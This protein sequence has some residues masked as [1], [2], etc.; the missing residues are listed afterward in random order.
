MRLSACL[1][2]V[3]ITTTVSAFPS[4]FAAPVTEDSAPELFPRQI[5]N[6]TNGP[7]TR[8][9]WDGVRDINTDY[10]TDFPVTGRVREYWLTVENSTFAPDGYR[11]TVL[12]F[13]G[14]LPGPTLYADWGDTVRIHVTNN[15]EYNGTSVHWHGVRQLGTTEQDGVNGITQCPCIP[16]L[17]LD[18]IDANDFTGALAP[19]NSQTYEW[20][21]TQ[22]GPS[23]YHSHFSLQYADGA[24][25]ALVIN[26][27]ASANYDEDLGPILLGDW[28]HP[29]AFALWQNIP[30]DGPQPAD[31]GLINGM[32]VFDCS[33][34]TDTNCVGGGKRF[35]TE[36]KPGKKYLLRFI[37][38]A[39]DTFF[40]VSLDNH[41]MT[42][43]STDFVPIKPY[44]TEFISI[45]IGERY[46]VIIEANQATDNYWLRAISQAACGAA[47]TNRLNIRGIVQYSGAKNTE[48]TS[49]PRFVPGSCDD[50]PMGKLVP[51]VA[52]DVPPSDL[53]VSQ[54]EEVTMSVPDR[55]YWKLNGI[56]AKIDWSN[57]TLLQV[58]KGETYPEDYSVLE[59]GRPNSWYYLVIET[60]LPIEHPIHL[61]GHDFHL[62]AQEAGA[63]DASKVNATWTNPPRR[64]VAMLPRNGYMVIAFKTDNPGVWL[65]H[66]HIA[67]HVSGGFALQFVERKAELVKMFNPP[68]AWHD[69][70]STWST[71]S[72]SS[73]NPPQI[74]SGL[75]KR[76]YRDF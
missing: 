68:S 47:N 13:N 61:H 24:A 6:C 67:W 66:C 35:H 12:T 20:N 45:G 76:V 49:S 18:T 71:Y 54:Q 30:T 42:I 5:P 23:W 73:I 65:L 59:I 4:L 37:N 44:E 34:L 31:N 1:G 62:I 48:P 50:E 7:T 53:G 63:F 27:P 72:A 15:L 38:I 32:N 8:N 69:T 57:P 52:I 28:Y 64:D 2:V 74:D 19:G 46:Q 22:Y 14:T 39:T 21:A 43:I 55:I 11:R 58:A 16:P 36:F 41:T 9:C 17:T 10:Y 56:S 25:G 51:V 29:T 3:I 70:C 33:K 75:R 26:G 60:A 40:K